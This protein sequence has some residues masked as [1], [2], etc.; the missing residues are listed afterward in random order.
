[1]SGYRGHKRKIFA[2]RIA[3]YFDLPV[4]IFSWGMNFEVQNDRDLFVEGCTG[5][6]EYSDNCVVFSG[7][8]MK[9]IANGEKFELFT[10][11]DGRVKLTGRI[12]SIQI[13]RSR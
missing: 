13:E 12:T 11:A 9:I 8:D 7:K 5:I 6:S 3:E 4:T 10:F 2:E 1:M